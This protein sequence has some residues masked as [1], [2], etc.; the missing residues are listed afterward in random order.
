MFQ[1][2]DIWQSIIQNVRRQTTITSVPAVCFGECNDVAV[3]FE[4]TE[5]DPSLCAAN[6]DAMRDYQSC[7][8]CINTNA[9]NISSS[10]ADTSV[11]V[12]LQQLLDSCLDES[13]TSAT[14]TQSATPEMTG[15][16][17]QASRL[18]VS[19]TALQAEL[20]SLATTTSTFQATGTPLWGENPAQNPTTV[21]V[22]STSSSSPGSASGS[23]ASVIVPAVIVPVLV[24]LF[25]AIGGFLFLRRRRRY[26]QR[27]AKEDTPSL[28]SETP[29]SLLGIKAELPVNE[30]RPELDATGEIF[31]LDAGNSKVKQEK[32]INP[33]RLVELPAS[34]IPREEK[35]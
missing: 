11:L 12:E 18:I 3:I 22:N 34:H 7:V 30:F 27:Q 21:Y 31:Q 9:A 35:S 32:E 26:N 33:G 5:K 1:L 8:S 24:L 16:I 29:P 13:G 23:P 20:S 19:V 14:Q 4:T 15:V 6:S 10:G 25:M 17:A 2:R 28:F